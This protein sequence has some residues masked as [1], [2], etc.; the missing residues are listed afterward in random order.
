[1]FREESEL[2]MNQQLSVAGVAMHS[3]EVNWIT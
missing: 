3:V 2:F 1:M